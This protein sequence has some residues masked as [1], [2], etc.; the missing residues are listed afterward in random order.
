ME[1]LAYLANVLLSARGMRRVEAAETA[2]SIANLGLEHLRDP[3]AN[4]VKLFRV[5]WHRY[6]RQGRAD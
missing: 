2:V 5:G 1:E 4:A 6:A 3:T